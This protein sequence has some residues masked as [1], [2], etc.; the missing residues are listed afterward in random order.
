M[1]AQDDYPHR[2]V[3]CWRIL[4]R[5]LAKGQ[6]KVKTRSLSS[7]AAVAGCG[8]QCLHSLVDG[9]IMKMN[10]PPSFLGCMRVS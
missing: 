1:L 7:K 9:G 6:E 2:I 3:G 10:L 5:T 8:T 4:S